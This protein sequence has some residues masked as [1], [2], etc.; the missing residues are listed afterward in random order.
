M[1]LNFKA[2]NYKSFKD[3][4]V[5]SMIPAPKQKE[6]EYSIL[7]QKIGTKT[8][9]AICS[10]VLYGPNASG[11]TNIIGAMD[12]FKNIVLRGNIRNSTDQNAPDAAAHTLELIP[13]NTASENE[14]VM[15]SISFIEN[16]M[17]I[18]YAISADIGKFL[19]AGYNRKIIFWKYVCLFFFLSF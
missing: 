8:H 4:F 15:F 11:K 7:K 6:L 13:N 17:L 1:L 2:K 19:D 10:A 16:D 3:E 5:F 14:P 18:E 9:K 12:A